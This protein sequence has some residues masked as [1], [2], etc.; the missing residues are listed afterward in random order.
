M[1]IAPLAVIAKA[2]DGRA[3][4]TLHPRLCVSRW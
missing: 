1:G 4:F 2:R 3:E